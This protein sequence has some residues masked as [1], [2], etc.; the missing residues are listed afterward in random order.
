MVEHDRLE[1]PVSSSLNLSDA[2]RLKFEV[3]AL[4]ISIDDSAAAELAM[5]NG[6]RPLTPADYASTSG[7]IL[8][9]D[10]EVWVNAP[11][12]MYNPNFVGATPYSLVHRGGRFVVEGGGLS[13]NAA[14]WL[15]PTYHGQIGSYGMALNDFVFTHGDRVRLAPIQ[16]CA[17]TC[18]FCNLPYEF[19]YGLKSIEAMVDAVSVALA[20]PLQPARHMLI[21]GG[22]PKAGDVS[23][24][25]EVY[26]RML[27]SFP[28]LE[29]D[30]MMAPVDG[31]F[32][33]AELRDLGV[34]QLSINLE[35]FNSDIARRIMRQKHQQGL[36]LYLRFI[37]SAS[38]LLGAGSVRSMLL[39]GAE[40]LEDTLAGA[41]RIL[42]AGGIPVLSPFR[43][44]PATP[45]R[46]FP[47]P[48]AD[49]LFAAY[50][51]CSALAASC[52]TTLGPDCPPCTHN[53]LTL[54]EPASV[55]YR[56][57]HPVVV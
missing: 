5:R 12:E 2:Q 17:M 34:H 23:Y 42:D 26:R 57:P 21:S 32:D 41:R 15:P 53:T 54:L 55:V 18:K 52:G 27:T 35:I 36:D 39:V 43:P 38:T 20:D 4:G 8:K 37:D 28:E 47:P 31:V 22:T 19:R 6:D 24:L 33:L 29:I 3:L 51:E 25:R 40:P 1:Q 44:D 11:I 14:F 10:D 46:D 16:G 45:L 50:V 9:L 7:V 56:H 30:I 49:D 13:S 48:S